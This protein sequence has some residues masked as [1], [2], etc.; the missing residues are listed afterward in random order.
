MTSATLADP[1]QGTLT[2]DP[3]TLAW[4]FTPAAGFTAGNAIINYIDR[5]SGRR[6]RYGHSM[7]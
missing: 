4:T 2:Q 3:V 5:G 7:W 1:T 6:H